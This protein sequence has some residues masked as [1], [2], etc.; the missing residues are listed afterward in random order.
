MFKEEFIS[1]DHIRRSMDKLRRLKQVTSVFKYLSD[2]RN[3][4]LTIPDMAEGERLDRFMDG[5]MGIGNMETQDT[6]IRKGE[7]QRERDARVG[8][9]FDCH[10]IGCRLW[11]HINTTRSKNDSAKMQL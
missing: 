5:P 10:E 8:A 3:I 2:F 9:C 7:S 6:K 11:N 1:E 4:I